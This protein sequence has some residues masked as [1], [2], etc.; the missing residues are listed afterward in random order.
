ME[1]V[2]EFIERYFREKSGQREVARKHHLALLQKFFIDDYVKEVLNWQTSQAQIISEVVVST[3]LSDTS[4][5]IITTEKIAKTLT[6][7]NRYRLASTD[8]MWKI[9]SQERKCD[10]CHGT[11]Q[12]NGGACGFCN[13]AGWTHLYQNR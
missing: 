9:T 5:T 8:G 11:G 7:I 2:Q 4:A 1:T 12:N 10:L 3:E 6:R 13:G